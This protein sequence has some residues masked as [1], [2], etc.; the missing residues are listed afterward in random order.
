MADEH[1][2]ARCSAVGQAGR[3]LIGSKHETAARNETMRFQRGGDLVKER[4]GKI[5][6]GLD[7]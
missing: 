6:R 1:H 3:G 4:I 7:L 5:I 2:A